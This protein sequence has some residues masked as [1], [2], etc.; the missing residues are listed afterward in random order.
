MPRVARLAGQILN[1]E[2]LAGFLGV[3][4]TQV[5]IYLRAG[6]PVI[7]KGAGRRPY[8]INSADALAWLRAREAETR[9]SAGGV[10]K[11][12]AKQRFTQAAAELKELQLAERRGELLPAADVE[13]VWTDTCARLRSRMMIIPGRAASLVA[14]ETD[15]AAIEGILEEEI[16]G[17]LSELSGEPT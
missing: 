14:N 12:Q 5:D 10:E 15:P 16:R 11:D 9:T 1:R 3:S 7:E 2:E 17:A 8:K 13:A 4:T 6:C